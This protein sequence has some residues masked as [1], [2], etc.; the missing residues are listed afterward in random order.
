[1]TKQTIVV[2][3]SLMVNFRDIFIC[4]TQC[5]IIIIWHM[6]PG[7]TEISLRIRVVDL[8][9]EHKQTC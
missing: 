3:G 4:E 2:I 6:L 9:P 1:M 7:K 5:G 8:L